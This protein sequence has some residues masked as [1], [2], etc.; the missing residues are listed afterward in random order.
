MG[1][2]VEQGAG[3]HKPAR[4]RHWSLG[5]AVTLGR[6][7]GTDPVRLL[8]VPPRSDAGVDRKMSVCL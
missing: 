1:G 2:T 7:A 5:T 6:G 8:P 3:D 4:P